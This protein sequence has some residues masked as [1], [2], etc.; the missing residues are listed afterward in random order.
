MIL[1]AINASAV[2]V[3]VGCVLF[4]LTHPMERAR[5]FLTRLIGRTFF[6][7]LDPFQQ[8]QRLGFFVG[9]VL[10]AVAAAE[11]I[12]FVIKYANRH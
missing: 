12:A 10:A 9:V 7:K 11:I 4:L 8:Q 5:F 2:I 6:P 1:R 3:C